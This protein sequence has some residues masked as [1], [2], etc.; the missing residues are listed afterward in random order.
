MFLEE[1]FTCALPEISFDDAQ[2]VE[3]P[4]IIEESGHEEALGGTAGLFG[5][6]DG[7]GEGVDAAS[8]ARLYAGLPTF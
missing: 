2:S 5:I 1:S 4:L 3:A 6:L 8:L 7:F